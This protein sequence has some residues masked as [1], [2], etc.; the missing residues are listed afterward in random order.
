MGCFT[1]I[2]LCII[3]I[4]VYIIHFLPTFLESFV[5]FMYIIYKRLKE[6]RSKSRLLPRIKKNVLTRENTGTVK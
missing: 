2:F 3:Y 1:V 6:S 5:F 4:K